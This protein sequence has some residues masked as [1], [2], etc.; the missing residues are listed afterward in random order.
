MA[1]PRIVVPAF[2]HLLFVAFALVAHAAG[3]YA[4]QFPDDPFAFICDAP[5]VAITV[6]G[7]TPQECSLLLTACIDSATGNACAGD[8]P[9]VAKDCYAEHEAC[10][11][12]IRDT[13]WPAVP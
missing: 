12:W 13:C 3:E 6:E 5:P 2:I 1:L 7:A 8:G 9:D 11:A 4:D 10:I